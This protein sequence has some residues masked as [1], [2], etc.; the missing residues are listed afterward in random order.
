[1]T[2]VIPANPDEKANFYTQNDDGSI[3]VSLHTILAW[4][5]EYNNGTWMAEPVFSIKVPK[6][7]TVI[8][9]A[10]KGS[11]PISYPKEQINRKIYLT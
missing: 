9:L 3:T 11:P 4:V 5:V 10:S 2:T 7:T 1:M 6:G 8:P